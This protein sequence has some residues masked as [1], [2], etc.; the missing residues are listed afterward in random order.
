MERRASAA[1]SAANALLASAMAPG[2]LVGDFT[3][4]LGACSG[5][6]TGVGFLTLGQFIIGFDGTWA[7]ALGQKRMLAWAVV[8]WRSNCL[9]FVVLLRIR[10]DCHGRFWEAAAADQKQLAMCARTFKGSY[11]QY[12]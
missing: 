2:V 11:I 4:R 7:H 6:H 3:F 5:F 9:C 10:H 8:F 1:H 12:I